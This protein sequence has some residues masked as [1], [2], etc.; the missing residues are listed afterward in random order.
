V[1]KVRLDRRA[2]AISLLDLPQR[3][4]YRMYIITVRRITSG[5][6]LK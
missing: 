3:S 5:E 4:G 1:I 2:T 6:L